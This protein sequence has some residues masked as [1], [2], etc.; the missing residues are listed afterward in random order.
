MPIYEYRCAA[1]GERF[2]VLQRLGEGGAGLSCPRCG[3][4]E[5]DKQFS[6]FAGIAGGSGSGAAAD[7]G[8]G[9]SQ[10]CRTTSAGF[11]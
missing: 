1:C 6:T 5:V 7:A 10:C 2:E 11:T 3:H 4:S 8:C 9:S